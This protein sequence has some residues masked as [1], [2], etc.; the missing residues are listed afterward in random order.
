MVESALRPGLSDGELSV[1]RGFHSLIDHHNGTWMSVSDE[2]RN[3]TLVAAPTDP[4][5]GP[6][7]E[8]FMK[9]RATRAGPP[10]STEF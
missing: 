3:Y 7:S 8:R 5:S 4:S 1:L 10:A 2:M 6:Y 9:P